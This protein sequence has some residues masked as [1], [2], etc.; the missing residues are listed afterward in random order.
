M[1]A[2]S[3]QRLR[4]WSN[5][6]K[7]LYKCL[8]GSALYHVYVYRIYMYHTN[9]QL[10]NLAWLAGV[11]YLQTC[12]AWNERT[13]DTTDDYDGVSIGPSDNYSDMYLNWECQRC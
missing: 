10:F 11:G 4:R 3:A 1:Y 2:T 5:V 6:V 7:M 13:I 9:I 8:L 12:M